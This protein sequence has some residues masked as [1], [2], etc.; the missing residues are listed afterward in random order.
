MFRSPSR[1]LAWL[2]VVSFV[3]VAGIWITQCYKPLVLHNGFSND[4]FSIR[5]V[6]NDLAF[7]DFDRTQI[8]AVGASVA[9]DGV[10]TINV[11]IRFEEML[12][13]PGKASLIEFANGRFF[14]GWGRITAGKP[15]TSTPSRGR[16][17]RDFQL[18]ADLGFPLWPLLF[19][20]GAWVIWVLFRYA[21]RRR[22][23]M[24]DSFR[25][26]APCRR[27][28]I[29]SLA[30]FSSSVLLYLLQLPAPV[31]VYNGFNPR[32]GKMGLT[33]ALD[34]DHKIIM[35]SCQS[36]GTN[37]A[38]PNVITISVNPDEVEDKLPALGDYWILAFANDALEIRTGT[39]T[40]STNP[41]NPSWKARNVTAPLVKKLSISLWIGIV[42]FGGWFAYL[43]LVPSA[44]YR[45]RKRL[46]LCLQ[47]G[48]DLR[49]SIDRCPECGQAACPSRARGHV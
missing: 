1:F 30:F 46:G 11:P 44:T 35:Q 33:R 19:G 49:A 9:R 3:T 6:T 48:Y 47:C 36:I 21:R 39:V 37:S 40:A 2:G 7:F 25:A 31:V 27:P 23:W 5:P 43:V 10:H 17:F 28:L 22:Q 45:N 42:C 16:V 15:S 26:T 20:L 41:A 8:K 12:P 24:L 18:T 4:F 32:V 38:R 34:W 14:I 13:E 29:A